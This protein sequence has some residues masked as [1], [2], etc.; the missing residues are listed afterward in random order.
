MQHHPP[1]MNCVSVHRERHSV[2]WWR[3]RTATIWWLRCAAAVISCLA[4]AVEN[5]STKSKL[6]DTFVR[7]FPP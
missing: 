1:A 5:D 4:F 3:Q 2:R 7:S 6:V